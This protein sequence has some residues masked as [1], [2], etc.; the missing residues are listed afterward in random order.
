MARTRSN[1][2]LSD[3]I[4]ARRSA[5]YDEETVEKAQSRFQNFLQG[6]ITDFTGAA[7]PE[8]LRPHLFQELYISGLDLSHIATDSRKIPRYCFAELPEASIKF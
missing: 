2:F 7:A 5:P 8:H 3:E 1:N 4:L 6:T